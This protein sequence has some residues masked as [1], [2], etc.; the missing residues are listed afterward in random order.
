[1]L[2]KAPNCA[3]GHIQAAQATLA[4]ERAIASSQ[5]DARCPTDLHSL[6]SL[7]GFWRWPSLQVSCGASRP[8]SFA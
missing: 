7:S 5:G 1:L 2:G 4:C 3:S 6:A 8:S